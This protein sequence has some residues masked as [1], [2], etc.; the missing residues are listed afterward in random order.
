M[1]LRAPSDRCNLKLTLSFTHI[2]TECHRDIKNS[3]HFILAADLSSLAFILEY[4]VQT[5]ADI[6]SSFSPDGLVFFRTLLYY[7]DEGTMTLLKYT[8]VEKYWQ[9]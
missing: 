6:Y 3:M 1:D 8:R 2:M 7:W 4:S 9:I 5:V